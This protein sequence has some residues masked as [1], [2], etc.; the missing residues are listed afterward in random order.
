MPGFRFPGWGGAAQL[1]A[2]KKVA[3]PIRINLAQ[4]REL[5]AFAQFGSELDR[6]F[7]NPSWRG[8]PGG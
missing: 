7:P 1:N 6:S 3:G 4:F 5:E 2:M 8:A